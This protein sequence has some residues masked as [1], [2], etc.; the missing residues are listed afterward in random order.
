[1]VATTLLV[2]AFGLLAVLLVGMAVRERSTA[3]ADAVGPASPPDTA[4]MTVV[5]S[6]GTECS[7]GDV[8]GDSGD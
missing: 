3:H 8:D 4:L 5:F 7:A 1:M 2:M 6:G